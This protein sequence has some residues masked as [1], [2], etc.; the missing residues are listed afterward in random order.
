MPAIRLPS[1]CWAARPITTAVMAPPTASVA[2]SRPPTRSAS[3]TAAAII[4]TR[5]RNEVVPAV[6]GSMRRNSAGAAKR[7][8]S[9]ASSQ[10]RATI[11]IAA[12]TRTGV[13]AP[14]SSSRLT[15]A[16]TVIAISG[17][18]TSSSS[19]AYLAF[20]AVWIVRLRARVAGGIAGTWCLS[21]R[22]IREQ[23]TRAGAVRFRTCARRHTGTTFH[24][25][26]SRFTPLRTSSAASGPTPQNNDAC[27][28]LTPRRFASATAA[29]SRAS[30]SRCRR[31]SSTRCFQ[32]SW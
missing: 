31:R 18:I 8:R 30:R 7:P 29:R 14:N 9:R 6:A 12:P 16:A 25:L 27:A 3:S 13:S 21:I 24:G 1:V 11:A 15:Y 17:T 22:R 4:T 2:G 32:R 20:W 10:P 26:C 23:P 5:I 19:L 28:S